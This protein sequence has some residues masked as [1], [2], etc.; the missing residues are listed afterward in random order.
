MLPFT[1]KQLKDWAGPDVYRRA[2]MLV[3]NQRVFRSSYRNRKI[4]G[5][6]EARPR[7]ISCAVEFPPGDVAPVNLCPCRDNREMGL[8]CHHATALCLD[9]LKLMTDPVRMKRLQEEQRSADRIT[10]VSEADYLTRVPPGTPGAIAVKLLLEF[11]SDLRSVWWEDAIPLRL[12]IE[13]NGRRESIR[14]VKPGIPLALP[15][16]EDNLLFV[17]EDIAGGPVP[18]L[19]QISPRNLANVFELLQGMRVSFG[20][21]EGQVSRNK[22]PASARVSLDD[23]TGIMELGV[24]IELPKGF[25]ATLPAYWVEGKKAWVLLG[26]TL[27][28]LANVLPEPM[29]PMYV[30]PLRI[31]R[32]AVP[33]FIRKELDIFTKHVEIRMDVDLS[34]FHFTPETP[35]FRLDVRGSPASLSATLHANYGGVEWIAGDGTN[36][37]DFVLPDPDNV[38]LYR[39]RNPE[40]E[41]EAL[42]SLR[43]MGFGGERGDKMEGI[44]G[45]SAVMNFCASGLPTLRRRG[46]NVQL[47]GRIA[48]ELDAAEHLMPV[49]RVSDTEAGWFDVDCEFETRQGESLRLAD[50]RQAIAAGDAYVRKGD[51]L[52]LFDRDAVRQMF[53]LFDDCGK[54]AEGRGG[55]RMSAVHG[56]FLKS[57]LDALDGVDVEATPQWLQRVEAQNQPARL[58]NIQPSPN[59]KADLRPYQ[60]AGLNW[61]SFLERARFA[62]ILA[63]EMGL[64]KTL[65]TLAWIQLRR[66]D[67][68]LRECPALIV[69]PTSLV[70]NWI[71]EGGR[72]TPNLRFANLTGS[73][74]QREK[75]WNEDAPKAQVW[76]T[77]YAV[78]QR[79]VARYAAVMFSVVALDEAQN[80]K[81]RDTQNA[82]AVKQLQAGTRLVLTGTPVENSVSDLWSIMDFLM[83]GYLGLHDTFRRR[84]ES[85][86]KMGGIEAVEAQKRL[87]KKLQP[88]LLRR[89]KRDVAKDLPPKIEKVAWCRMTTDQKMVYTELVRKSQRKLEDMVAQQGFQRSRMEI[90]KT[91]LQLRQTCCHLELLKLPGLKSEA[92]S[93][94]LEMFREM[95]L[96]AVDGGHRVLVFSQFTSMLAI[97][98]REL[99]AMQLTYCYLDGSTQHRMDVVRRFQG[100]ATIPLFLISL[101]AGGTGLNLTGADMVIHYDPWWNPAVENQ[102]TDRAYRIGQ[103]RN[104]YSLKLITRDSVEEKVL[105]LQQRKQQVIDATLDTDG[106]MLQSLEWEDVQELLR[107]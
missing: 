102:A 95:I 25:E 24:D 61:L 90:L 72:F 59:L 58:E 79:D 93:G 66:D 5:M 3:D 31:Q 103:Q 51:R 57:T 12:L 29:Y 76:V 22:I 38:L 11:P 78:L 49:V 87:R 77:S 42:D 86:I 62:G 81:N 18:D 80:I 16:A 74:G 67:E 52:L 98:R 27:F 6:I 43:L 56:A 13:H 83:P 97:L 68:T 99:E 101:K 37:E 17:L 4:E 105:A 2:E 70:E 32:A 1:I 65:Q 96:E 20:G 26:D 10:R 73:P 39:T 106:Q 47:S 71:E 75:A 50:V 100:D 55:V 64:G 107:I 45:H 14:N 7:D 63:D 85:P 84:Y 21:R 23:E 46:W 53:D 28:P 41:R 69:C 8:F 40:A 9:Q 104:V 44:V 92:P 60:R 88:F 34:C 15:S 94:K 54:R 30:E 33:R 35:G 19:M 91:L 82:R 36:A 89:L 48:E